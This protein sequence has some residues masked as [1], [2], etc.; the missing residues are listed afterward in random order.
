MKCAGVWIGLALSLTPLCAQDDFIE[1]LLDPDLFIIPVLPELP[2]SVTIESTNF[3]YDPVTNLVTY[4][5]PF[6]L[7]ADTGPVITGRDARYN[8][9]TQ[10]VQL[11]GGV[12]LSLPDGTRVRAKRMDYSLK[13]ETANL[14]GEVSL[15]QPSDGTSNAVQLFSDKAVINVREQ[16][17]DMQGDVAIYAGPSLQRGSRVTYNYATRQFLTTSLRTAV[18]PFLLESGE[19]R[20]EIVNGRQVFVGE[21]AGLTTHDRADP[22]YWIRAKK[23]TLLPDD[24]VIFESL[25]VY[26]GGVPVFYFPYLSQ[27]LDAE[28]GYQFVPGGR[29]NWG[30][31]L[32]NRYGVMLGGER[33]PETGLNKD[34]WLLAQAH[35]DLYTRRGIG[36]GLDLRDTRREENENLTG[37]STYYLNDLDPSVRRAGES[38]GFVNEDRYKLQYR[39][40]LQL[41]NLLGGDASF[42]SDF[43][44]LSDRF[45]LEDFEPDVFR[46]DPEPDNVVGFDVANETSLLSLWA[47]LRLNDFYRTSPRLP[48]LS[49]DQIR[50][51][52]F[53]TSVL[54]EGQ[55]S[56]GI[57]RDQL[58]DFR[59]DDLREE[60]QQ[61]DLLPRRRRFIEETLDPGAFTRFNTYQEFSR[62]TNIG[63]WLTLVPRIGA[64]HTIY[65]D[66]NGRGEDDTRTHLF[67]GL[68][69]SVKFSKNYADLSNE[70]LGLDGLLHV[71]QPYAN[72][73][74]LR[75]DEL[76]SDFGRIDTLTPSTR[77]RLRTP[78]RFPALDDLAD[79]TV[80]RL[81][82][83][84]RLITQ[85]DDS[86]HLWLSLDTYL[87]AFANDPEGDRKVSNL[88]NDL[89]F[90]PVPWFR[91]NL[92]TQFPIVSGNEGFSEVSGSV[93]FM[94]TRSTELTVGNRFLRDHP[95]LRDSNLID[96]RV[97][98][99]FNDLWGVQAY[100]RWEFETG[101]LEVQE[102]NIHHDLESWVISAGLQFRDNSTV[103][104]FAFLLSFTL[105]E[106][107]D[108]NLPLSVDA[109][110][111][112]SSN[113]N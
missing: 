56:F 39:D 34:A 49:F 11:S 24:R 22:N 15:S 83:R 71:V 4:Q 82:L 16:T 52:I 6:K 25:K 95:I 37:L 80:F 108:V 68:E 93:T 105:K 3:D 10:R 29:S 113:R 96:L 98:H 59:R 88:Y 69:G 23:T 12:Q 111:S 20:S 86:S 57:Y 47:R 36:L 14:T 104:E 79:W 110:S 65:S 63:G 66:V 75:T 8:T 48:E 64:G 31:F 28:L 99:R 97:F 32:L 67:A 55:S 54:H 77:P 26:A 103:D 38:R 30:L 84:N 1:D 19:F 76:D 18:D 53:G 89:T 90:S 92:E 40:R 102:Y 100:H 101:T 60:F 33:D 62:P 21:N 42:F 112:G 87:D 41:G 94:P 50:R 58:A 13:S 73:S 44:L 107:P 7:V 27:P 46:E 9:E 5:G 43:T 74:W 2:E 35:V 72:A 45:F 106:F 61:D 17:A 70:R 85:R 51:P 78:G 91:A 109:G 81:G